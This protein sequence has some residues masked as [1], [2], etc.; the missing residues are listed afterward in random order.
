MR[1]LVAVIVLGIQLGEEVIRLAIPLFLSS[2]REPRVDGI[3]F[4][5]NQLPSIH[6]AWTTRIVIVQY[7]FLKWQLLSGSKARC[8]SAHDSLRAP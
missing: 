3:R 7:V 8:S 2:R 4:R 5:R 6:I 1:P